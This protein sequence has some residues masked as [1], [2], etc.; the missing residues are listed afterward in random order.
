MKKY[1]FIIIIV[2]IIL[3]VYMIHKKNVSK[4]LCEYIPE[5]GNS[6]GTTLIFIKGFDLKGNGGC[7]VCA[8]KHENFNQWKRL[9][10]LYGGKIKVIGYYSKEW[11]DIIK[12][13]KI[14]FK[15]MDKRMERNLKKYSSITLICERGKIIYEYKGEI[16]MEIYQKI[17][18]ILNKRVNKDKQT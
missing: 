2:I 16:S 17:K 11:K 14:N 6:S 4:D 9:N 1:I 10:Y 15:P 5:C 12:G 18:E 3:S 7:S 8:M 13:Y